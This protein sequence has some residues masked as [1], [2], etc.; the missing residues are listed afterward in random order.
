MS[1]A[2]EEREGLQFQ[3]P[4]LLDGGNQFGVGTVVRPYIIRQYV[5]LLCSGVEDEGELSASGERE[6]GRESARSLQCRAT[7]GRR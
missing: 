2:R 7:I 6:R 1:A 4:R 3:Y 5:R